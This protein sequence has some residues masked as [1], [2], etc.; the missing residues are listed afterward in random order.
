MD[1]T[2]SSA[3]IAVCLMAA[4]VAWFAG[5]ARLFGEGISRV[6]SGIAPTES[7]QRTTIPAVV[8]A[9]AISSAVL[10]VIWR[11]SWYQGL[12]RQSRED[13]RSLWGIPPQAN[14]GAGNGPRRVAA[15][16]VF[17]VVLAVTLAALMPGAI[18]AAVAVILGLV[19]RAGLAVIVVSAKG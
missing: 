16:S 9:I 12:L 4:N 2:R 8:I 1:R 10:L 7:A 15:V 17:V 3:V 19:A 6:L 14:A 18:P 5:L 13:L 11:S